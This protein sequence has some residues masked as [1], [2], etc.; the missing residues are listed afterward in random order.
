MKK[1]LKYYSFVYPQEVTTFVNGGGVEILSITYNP[2][3]GYVIFYY[4]I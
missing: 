4:E 1:E 2:T 3:W